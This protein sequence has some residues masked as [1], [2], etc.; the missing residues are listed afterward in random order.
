MVL[1]ALDNSNAEV[2]VSV[3]G[4]AGPGGGSD[5]KPVGL[6]Y[7]GVGLTGKEPQVKECHFTADRNSI[8]QQASEQA[9]ST[10]IDLVSSI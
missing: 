4:I 2:A 6:V 5:E 7:I 3:T 9:L 10:L 8:R 1:G